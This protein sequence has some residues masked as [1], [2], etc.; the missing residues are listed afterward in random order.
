MYFDVTP[1]EHYLWNGA[2]VQH[3]HERQNYNILS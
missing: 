3:I 2:Q 1:Y